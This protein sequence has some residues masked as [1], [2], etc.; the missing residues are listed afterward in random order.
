MYLPLY[1]LWSRRTTKTTLCEPF[2]F[3]LHFSQLEFTESAWNSRP[4]GIDF[5]WNGPLYAGINDY[6]CF[7]VSSERPYKFVTAPL[8]HEMYIHMDGLSNAL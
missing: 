7:Y 6:R 5:D 3:Q 4:R 2:T 1:D 8:S